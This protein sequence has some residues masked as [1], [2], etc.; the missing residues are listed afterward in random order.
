MYIFRRCKS[1]A[2]HADLN[3]DSEV[4]GT[5]LDIDLDTVVKKNSKYLKSQT[6]RVKDTDLDSDLFWFQPGS[7]RSERILRLLSHPEHKLQTCAACIHNT[8]LPV[9]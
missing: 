3:I 6:V 9:C 7:S 8:I 5:D 1:G 4:K 2:A